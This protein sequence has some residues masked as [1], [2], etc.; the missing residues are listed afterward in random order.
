MTVDGIVS[1]F[2]Q[3]KVKYS[4]LVED[5]KNKEQKIIEY[6]TSVENLSQARWI[7]SEVQKRFKERF[8]NLITLAIQ[9]VFDRPFRF[10]LEF[11]RKR[12]QMEC[13]VIIKEIVNGNER[14]YE[15]LEDEVGGSLIDIVSFAARV[16]LW[17]LEKPRSRNVIILDEPMKN[18]GQ[19]IFLG[20][21]ILKEISHRLK[22][23]LIIITHDK[24][25][26]D[27]GDKAWEVTH[28]GNESHLKLVKELQ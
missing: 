7:M 16:V 9:S 27:I 6:K 1:S 3:S 13:Q 28:D 17:S 24:Q 15:E 4:L 23:Q 11:E 5:C 14:V 2:M 20:G 18:M 26:I 22:F 19:L 10:C 8:E 21:Q 12:N 25:L